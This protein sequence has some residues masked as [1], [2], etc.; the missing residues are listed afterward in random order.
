MPLDIEKLNLEELLALN[1]Q[2]IR[3]IKYFHGLKTQAHL[4]RFEVGDQVSFLSNGR[5]VEGIVTRVNH[6]SLSVKTKDSRWTIHP[7]FSPRF[8]GQAKKGH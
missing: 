3:R 6:K 4:D 1:R 7:S 2:V 8:P 5:A